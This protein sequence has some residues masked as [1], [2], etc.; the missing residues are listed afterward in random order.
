MTR[1]ALACTLTLAALTGL[2]TSAA[3]DLPAPGPNGQIAFT[4]GRGLSNVTSQIWL[5]SS[6]GGS[7]T[8]L[9]MED[10]THFRHPTWSPDHTKIAYAAVANANGT[11][12][13]QG[14]WDIFVRDLTQPPS[15]TN[16]LNITGTAT[17][18]EERPAWSPD[19]NRIAY[20]VFQNGN[21]DI[22]TRPSG[23]GSPTP[24]ATTIES[25]A[26]HAGSFYNR[27]H[28]SPDSSTIY[29]GELVGGNHDIRR[30]AADGSQV[31]GVD[32]I[33]GTTND[34]QPEVSPDG[35][36]LCFTRESA[37]GDK[38]VLVAPVAGGTGA[39]VGTGLVTDSG[40]GVD[41]YECA[42][43][44]DQT[45]IAF[46]RGAQDQGQVRMGSTVMG[47][48]SSNVSDVS[49]TFDGNPDWAINFR[50]VCQDVS[51]S[52]AFNSFVSIPLVCSDR[53]GQ[54]FN[55]EIVTGPAHG[56]LGGINNDQVIYTP[57]ANYQGPDSFTFKSSDGNSD[58]LPATAQITVGGPGAGGG[59]GGGGGPT[60]TCAGKTATIVGT[61]G[62]DVLAGTPGRDVIAAL[63]GNDT[64]RGGRGKDLICAGSGRDRVA[65]GRGNDRVSGGTG[66][67]RLLGNGGNDVLNA[68]RGR[69]TLIG[70]RGRDRLN[71]GAARD[72]CR[73]SLG[74]DR[75]SRC[76]V[77]TGIP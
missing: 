46:T 52:V 37:T 33:D 5:L 43:S 29:Y 27:P 13:F 68:N 3:A 36:K 4:S 47:G 16:P 39:T 21:I 6:P 32:V 10:T 25:T 72:V 22:E 66:G 61:T 67:D 44:P 18:G 31:N 49:M 64:V 70:G 34:Y 9:T 41:D 28:W 55:P 53:D 50:P 23:G 56:N 76:E 26:T 75:A 57:N 30:S 40:G 11:T 14:P 1:L 38:D 42:W 58:S 2:A 71:G 74:T 77:R 8:R 7:P 69:D 73:G 15:G 62:S 17:V 19:G 48:A 63:G 12:A 45:L 24:I 20:Q 35:T 60:P 54:A 59:G 51:V 65:G